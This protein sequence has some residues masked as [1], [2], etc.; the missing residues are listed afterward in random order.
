MAIVGYDNAAPIQ[1]VYVGAHDEFGVD[2]DFWM[3]YVSPSPAADIFSDDALSE[4]I[5]AWDSG[6]HYIG[7]VTAPYQ[8]RL[9]GSSAEGLADAQSAC[10]SAQA[11]YYDVSPLDLSTYDLLDLILDDE[12]ST[13]LGLSYWNGWA[14]YVANYNFAGLNKY[15]VYPNCYCTPE[16]PYANCS[17]FR[18]TTGINR[19]A[20]IWVPEWEPCGSIANPPGWD[21]QTCSEV[22]GPSW[23]PS[24]LWQFGEQ[25]ACGLSADVDMNVCNPGINWTFYTFRLV[26][27]P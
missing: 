17:T 10:A 11:A 20:M 5:G 6:G 12:Y 8:S 22:G 26:A 16:S 1:D 14:N 19:P 3:R 4:C 24:N 13:P 21:A 23:L 2:P 25:G 27:A 18:Q 7:V 9:S 15:P